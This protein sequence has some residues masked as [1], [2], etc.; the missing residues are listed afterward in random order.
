M[1]SLLVNTIRIQEI[2]AYDDYKFNDHVPDQLGILDRTRT[3]R[4]VWV[5]TNTPYTSQYGLAPS[6]H[7]SLQMMQIKNH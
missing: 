3:V 7:T 5:F 2:N 6:L 1:V 4:T